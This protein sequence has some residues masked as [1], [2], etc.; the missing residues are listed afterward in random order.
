MCQFPLQTV[1]QVLVEVDICADLTVSEQEQTAKQPH[2]P[3]MN[4]I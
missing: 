2:E 1:C 3:D 4:Q